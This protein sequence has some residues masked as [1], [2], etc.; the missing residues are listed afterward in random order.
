[1]P[2][3]ASALAALQSVGSAVP[4]MP[5]AAELEVEAV[6]EVELELESEVEVEVVVDDMVAAQGQ[7]IGW[8]IGRTLGRPGDYRRVAEVAVVGLAAAVEQLHDQD[9]Y[10]PVDLK[11]YCNL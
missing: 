1:M 6:V 10:S 2:V 4:S 7:E 3:L 11:G 8:D 9:P 5:A